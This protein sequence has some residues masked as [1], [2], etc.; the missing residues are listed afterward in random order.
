M[1]SAPE[2]RT[3]TKCTC[4]V[5]KALVKDTRVSQRPPLFTMT[6]HSRGIDSGLE[7]QAPDLDKPGLEGSFGRS[8]ALAKNWRVNKVILPQLTFC[9]ALYAPTTLVSSR[10]PKMISAFQTYALCLWSQC[11]LV[12][13]LERS[14]KGSTRSHTAHPS[15]VVPMTD[16]L[17]DDDSVDPLSRSVK[18]KSAPLEV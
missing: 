14:C 5:L 15:M 13:S 17:S 6:Q 1:V 10:L 12:E 11:S 7:T 18:L 4:R 3:L 9:S 16:P 8:P 2:W